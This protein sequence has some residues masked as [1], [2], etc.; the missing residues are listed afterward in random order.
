MENGKITHF[1]VLKIAKYRIL[2]IF[3]YICSD[4]NCSV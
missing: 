4:K 1:G 3:L 2:N